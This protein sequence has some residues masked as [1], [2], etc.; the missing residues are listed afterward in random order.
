VSEEA[1]FS[2]KM[3][4][5]VSSIVLSIVNEILLTIKDVLLIML[6][7]EPWIIFITVAIV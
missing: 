6:E 4:D 3:K 5:A 7:L 1:W 2:D